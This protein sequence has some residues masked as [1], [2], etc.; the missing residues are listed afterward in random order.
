MLFGAIVGAGGSGPLSDRIGRRRL[1]LFIALVF[2]VGSLVLAFSTNIVMLVIGRAIVG[3]AVGGSMSTVP[4]YLTEMAPTE[5][6]GS[7][8][9]LNQLMIT[10]G[11]L[12][13][14]LVNYAFADMGAWRWML[15]LAVVPSLILLIG[16]AFMPESPRWLLENRS[17]KAARDVMK[18]TYNPDAIDAEI[19][20][21][22]EIASQSEST[23]SVIK[24]P[25]LR[26][27]LI[28]GCIFAIFQ[29]FIGINAVIFYAPTIFTK[30]GLGGSAS[31]IGTVGIGVVNVLVTILALF[32]VDRVDRKKLLV[33]GNIGMIASLVIMAMLIWSI[34]IQSS[35]WVIIICLSL[36]IVFFGISWGPVLWVM[37]PEL[38]PTRARG[39]ATGIAALV[40][41]FGTL[42]VAQLFPILNH[43]LDTEWV[44][45][46]FAAIGVLAMFFVIKYLPETRGR[47][48][49]EIEHELRLRTGV[50]SE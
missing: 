50:K 9:S 38:F 18:I 22:K 43:H 26:P 1:V 27:T 33:I 5:L 31:I 16:V 44:F 11:I 4:V 46:I 23:F 41:N 36:F 15:G 19:K 2:I 30:A 32:I 48:L 29:Q 39:A 45:L 40:L 20:E 28:I 49:A 34:G 17:E 3:L 37:L 35:A 8:G 42:I 10:I 25:W 24:S 47:S 14:Y 13:A 12:A 21:M 7:L 6:R